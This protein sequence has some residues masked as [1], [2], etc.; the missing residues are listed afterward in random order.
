MS[1]AT[2]LQELHVCSSTI[3]VSR[4][5]SAEAEVRQIYA[6]PLSAALKASPCLQDVKK[7]EAVVADM[8]HVLEADPGVNKRLACFAGFSGLEDNAVNIIVV[9]HTTPAATRVRESARPY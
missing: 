5:P 2:C 1:S 9:C 8:R 4:L 6:A 3:S 7:V